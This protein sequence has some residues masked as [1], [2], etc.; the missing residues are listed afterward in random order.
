VQ[1]I[2]NC[3][4]R[5]RGHPASSSLPGSNGGHVA[6]Y[7]QYGQASRLEDLRRRRSSS[8]RGSP[9][10]PGAG[11]WVMRR[12]LA[13]IQP[14]TFGALGDGG[15]YHHLGRHIGRETAKPFEP[16]VSE[17]KSFES[18]S[19]HEFAP[20][21]VQGLHPCRLKLPALKAYQRAQTTIGRALFRSSCQYPI[22]CLAGLTGR[23][24][25]PSSIQR[26]DSPS[27]A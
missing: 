22:P 17:R 6:D 26:R 20:G 24:S 27:P 21:R 25:A 4:P 8:R 16:M 12:P 1:T 7:R 19:G 18:P 23:R 15:R 10:S 14:R 13:S 9:R 3:F 11:A 5:T 2:T